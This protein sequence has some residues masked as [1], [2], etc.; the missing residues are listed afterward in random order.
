MSF[1]RSIAAAVLALAGTAASAQW[2]DPDTK[3]PMP[4]VDW[5]KTVDGLGGML[6][7]TRDYEAFMKEWSQTPESHTPNF[8]PASGAKHGD[9][10]TAM[11]FFS[12]CAEPGKHC[13]LV[14]DFKVLKP[15]GSVY[16]NV[17]NIAAYSA[18]VPKTNVLMLTKATIRLTI[19]PKDPSGQ[20]TIEATMRQPG[21][22]RMMTLVQYLF[23]E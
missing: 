12:G 16:G 9:S 1:R 10:V 5:R 17:P 11:V 3:K 15:D 4:D 8:R 19:E 23:V 21:T 18:N 7:L 6:V 14:V 20:Y 2:M 13:E 22:N